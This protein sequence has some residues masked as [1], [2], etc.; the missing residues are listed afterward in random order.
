VNRL[1]S[2]LFACVALLLTGEAASAPIPR[3]C[4]AAWPAA[5]A[6]PRLVRIDADAAVL[7]LGSLVV[8]RARLTEPPALTQA[9]QPEA[10]TAAILTALASK[11]ARWHVRGPIEFDDECTLDVDADLALDKADSS[12]TRAA[13]ALVLLGQARSAS[14]DAQPERAADLALQALTEL[15][16]IAE[17]P[18]LATTIA[19][20]AIDGLIDQRQLGRARTLAGE[21]APQI[22]GKLDREQPAALRF[23][24]ATIRFAAW[25]DALGAREHLQPRLEASFGS[26][27][28]PALENRVRYANNLIVL[29][30]ARDSLDAFE[31][32]ETLLHADPRPIT[33]LRILLARSHAN[34]LA[35][36]GQQDAQIARLRV[37]RRELAQRYGDDDRRVID[38]D[39]DI[40]RGFAD[41]ARLQ[42]ALALAAR[43][44]LW[45]DRMLGPAHPRTQESTRLLALL[46]GRSGRYG[47]ARAL[48]EELLRRIDPLADMALTIRTWRDIATWAA[49][50]GEPRAALEL[51]GQAHRAAREQ[52]SAD[53]IFSIGLSI[54]YGWLLI[55]AGETRAG[56]ELL[57]SVRAH[58]PVANGLRE[59]A[60]AGFARC[61]LASPADNSADAERAVALLDETFIAAKQ[62]VGPDNARTL[63][64]Q[65]LLAGAQLRLGHRAEAKRLLTDF[66]YRAERNRE[67]FATGSTVR[68][69]T[70][71]LW[72]AENDSMAGYR[73]LALLFAQDGDLDASLRVA[74]LA[75]DRQLRDRFA[76]RRWLQLTGDVP[77]AAALHALQARR[78]QIDE[79]IAVAGATSRV[80]LEAQRVG[81]ADDV[82]KLERA[83]AKRFPQAASAPTPTVDAVQ[84]RLAPDTALIAYQ[85]AGDTWWVTLIEHNS[86]RV[87]PL[88]H[89]ADLAIATR[90][91]TRSLRGEPVR[92]WALADGHW[93]LAYVRP[94]DAVAR[95]TMD[96]VAR[97]LG[98]ALLDPWKTL[99]PRVRRLV[100]VADDELIGLPLDALT[101]DAGKPAAVTQY[102]LIYAASFGGWIELRDRAAH[103]TWSRDLFAVAVTDSEA[104]HDAVAPTTRSSWAPLPSARSEIAQI[105]RL[106]PQSRVQTL[107]DAAATKAA[108]ESENRSGA[109][110][111][112]RFV[113]FATHA[114]V[115][116]AFAERASLVLAPSEGVSTYLTATELAGFSMSA[117]LVVL[118]ACETGVGRFEP[119]QGLL[120]FAFA[121]LAA[122]NEG[123]VLSLWPI[124]DGTT[125]HF[126]ARFYARMHAGLA[127]ADAL[128]ATKREFVRSLDPRERD[129][130]V[131]AAFLLY[132]GA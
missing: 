72:I 61:L 4:D 2:R 96:D 8:A 75:R 53:S 92:V 115:E 77:E 43:V 18:V 107:V 116:P 132:G 57:D 41:A 54:D 29:G 52:F 45:R 81:V 36:Q 32:L 86:A 78:Q 120:G 1:Q 49:L 119:G 110:A 97:R 60:D 11:P 9:T 34:V 73:T 44:F 55:R 71:G 118:S 129:P 111:R 15:G 64:W 114:Q 22:Q 13:R 6:Q 37:L 83:L 85:H 39:D 106:F 62:A 66:V 46:Y 14:G 88:H 17:Q 102:E 74:E 95:V 99:A 94:K 24:L 127:P 104:T 98:A 108:L 112:Y 84:A 58:A 82:D 124:A 42:E 30:R 25:P 79:A 70:F 103:H 128:A 87:A 48:L 109:L 89:S 121:A 65:S 123:A 7:K 31:A 26:R 19:A 76:E 131:W 56:C 27:S 91:W 105:E 80:R 113:H 69:S 59:W 50:D 40:A 122:G 47:T 90:A 35:L 68:D 3:A 38:V 16:P 101:L 130:R 33:P 125:A 12:T 63:V 20:L 67:A 23:E 5:A 28:L 51:M 126:M 10:A 100:V 117:Q 21:I 93:T